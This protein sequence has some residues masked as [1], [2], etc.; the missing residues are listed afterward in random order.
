MYIQ[1]ALVAAVSMAA[2]VVLRPEGAYVHPLYSIHRSY[3]FV[4]Y[5]D[6]LYYIILY[7]IILYHDIFYHI[8]F[9]YIIFCS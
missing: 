5:H 3:S 2:A 1:A 9:Y 8:I 4:L 7:H 6:M